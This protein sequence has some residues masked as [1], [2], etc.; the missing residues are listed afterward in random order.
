M[1]A[2]RDPKT[3]AQEPFYQLEF[4]SAKAAK[5]FAEKHTAIF[6]K[7]VEEWPRDI[8]FPPGSKPTFA[9]LDTRS[10]LLENRRVVKRKVF[11]SH[12]GP[13][14]CVLLSVHGPGPAGGGKHRRPPKTE[15][16]WKLLED[17]EIKLCDVKSTQRKG[18]GVEIVDTD[19][20]KIITKSGILKK[21]IVRC[22]DH[23]EAQRVVRD[24]H[25]K[26]PWEPSECMLLAEIID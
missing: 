19:G 1:S 21:W 13:G 6:S 5:H 2:V 12:A 14:E 24:F 4:E 22:F 3:L 23:S 26:R 18:R 16:I 8:P 20:A 17:K 10:T 15:E 7:P 11:I 9:V 25:M